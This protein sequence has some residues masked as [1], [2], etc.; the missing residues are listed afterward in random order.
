MNLIWQGLLSGVALAAVYALVTAGLSLTYRSS[1]VLNLAHGATVA[2]VAL[3]L[4]TLTDSG[5]SR[6]LGLL[7]GPVLG[8]ALAV[9][10]FFAVVRPLLSRGPLVLINVTLAVGIICGGLAQR[11]WGTDTRVLPELVHGRIHVGSA[12]ITGQELVVAALTALVVGALALVFR[13]TL[14]GK[15]VR[16]SAEDAEGAVTVGIVPTRMILF[17]T[18]VSGAL[19]GLAACLVVPITGIGAQSG[20]AFTLVAVTAAVLGGLGNVEGSLLGGV[21][22]GLVV[23]VVTSVAAA[24]VDVAQ[25]GLLL[26]VLAWRNRRAGRRGPSRSVPALRRLLLAGQVQS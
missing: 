11:W 14:V 22:L 18:V 4:T 25:F 5:M 2:L 21:V 13:R 26:A 16:A 7:A 9:V 15:A 12:V 17:A 24:W 10:L 3:S 8:A 1:G 20:N 23:G 19:A 6:W